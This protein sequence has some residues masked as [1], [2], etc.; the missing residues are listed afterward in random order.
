MLIGIRCQRNFDGERRRIDRGDAQDGGE[1]VAFFKPGLLVAP[2]IAARGARMIDNF[3]NFDGAFPNGFAEELLMHRHAL[4]MA[5]IAAVQM[6]DDHAQ[7]VE[8]IIVRHNRSVAGSLPKARNQRLERAS[9]IKGRMRWMTFWRS[10]S[11]N[12]A[13]SLSMARAHSGWI[14]GRPRRAGTSL[15]YF[16]V[17]APGFSFATVRRSNW[18]TAALGSALPLQIWLTKEEV[19]RSWRAVSDWFQLMTLMSLTNSCA[20]GL[21]ANKCN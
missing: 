16:M 19:T 18:S 20:S 2:R 5:G 17:T 14:G 10:G 8:V 7:P 1:V 13:R 9:L 12:R 6:L 15:T 21:I 4:E 11:S 3:E